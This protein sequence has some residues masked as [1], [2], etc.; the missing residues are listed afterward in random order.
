[1][2]KLINTIIIAVI[3]AMAM[4]PRLGLAEEFD[5]FL[6]PVQSEPSK[7]ELQLAKRHRLLQAHQY[8]GYATLTLVTTQ[9]ALGWA[10]YGIYRRRG[11]ADPAWDKIRQSHLAL[12]LGSFASYWTGAGFAIFAPKLELEDGAEEGSIRAHKRLAWVHGIGMGILPV[13]GWL[14]TNYRNDLMANQFKTDTNS[15]VPV[16]A[17]DAVA[18]SHGVWG[19]ATMGALAGAYISVMLR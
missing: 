2:K 15:G 19:T 12:G 7:A 11:I 9:V 1:M 4:P 3:C 13:W 6:I 14:T 10:N 8:I 16:S 18:V 5:P 17:Y